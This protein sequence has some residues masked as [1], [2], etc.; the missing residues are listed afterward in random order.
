MKELTISIKLSTDQL[1]SNKSCESQ[2]I[3]IGYADYYANYIPQVDFPGPCSLEDCMTYALS[4][5]KEELLLAALETY[6]SAGFKTQVTSPDSPQQSAAACH[7]SQPSLQTCDEKS[8]A[9]PDESD[10]HREDE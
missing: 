7:T 4:R 10:P 8:P 1:V 5:F 9:H 3:E 2:K 6:E